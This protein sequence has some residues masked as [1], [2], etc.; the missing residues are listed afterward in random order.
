MLNYFY[1]VEL[2]HNLMQ[3]PSI[4]LDNLWQQLQLPL[5]IRALHHT[6]VRPKISI[7]WNEYGVPSRRRPKLPRSSTEAC[8]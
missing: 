7:D 8:P 3:K 2:A 5:A 6:L 4:D 1:E